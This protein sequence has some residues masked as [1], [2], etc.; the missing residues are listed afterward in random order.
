MSIDYDIQ[1]EALA[2]IQY[3]NPG[4]LEAQPLAGACASG[5][6]LTPAA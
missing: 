2:I 5:S 4:D 3:R 1:D 6:P